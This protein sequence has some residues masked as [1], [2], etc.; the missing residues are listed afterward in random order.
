MK[1]HA[2]RFLGH[3]HWIARGRNRVVRWLCDPETVEPVG[4]EVDFFGHR[5]PGS[6]DHFID[7]NVFFYGA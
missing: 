1:H 2:V 3:Q 5:Y 4:F 7:W 6:L